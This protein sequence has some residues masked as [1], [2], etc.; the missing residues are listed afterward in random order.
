M[1]SWRCPWTCRDSPT[2]PLSLGLE[3]GLQTSR[4]VRAEVGD[5]VHG[6]FFASTVRFDIWGGVGV[7][8]G[9]A[10]SFFIK[11]EIIT[12]YDFFSEI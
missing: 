5:Y 3:L 11:E 6:I 8:I 12:F 10:L 9:D 1:R 7:C 2:S 4:H